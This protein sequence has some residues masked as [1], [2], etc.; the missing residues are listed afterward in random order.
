MTGTGLAAVSIDERLA[1][2]RE[3]LDSRCRG[4]GGRIGDQLSS[5]IC[6]PG[7]MLRARFCLHL[8]A[9][10][11]VDET[12][13]EI[14]ARVIE[15]THN[16]SL[17]HDDCVDKADV[18]RGHPTPNFL[19]SETVALLLGD[20][21][22]SQAMD[23]ALNLSHNA[24]RGLTDAVQEM[25]VGELQEEFLK[26]SVDLSVDAYMG[27]A[28]RKTGALFEWAGRA[29]SDFSPLEHARDDMPKL[30]RT[31]GILLQ[32]VDDIHDF[33]LS[34][35]VAGKPKGKDLAGDRMTLPVLMALR[36]PEHKDAAL[37]LW[38]QAHDDPAGVDKLGRFLDR[39]GALEATREEAAA[40]LADMMGIIN[41]LPNKT[42]ADE[43]SEFIANMS[44]RQF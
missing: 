43:F 12:K 1:R 23:E 5:F 16:A 36:K 4:L 29:L 28:A 33:T 44:F 3:G 24:I 2:V 40:M 13:A 10:L 25:T 30:G 38:R 9:S 19:F 34:D 39:S 8:G 41:G 27:V 17:L 35:D 20:L 6:R 14:C 32:V 11:G 7:K 22:F 42:A 15:L 26:G 18:R 21:A 31:A 37:Q